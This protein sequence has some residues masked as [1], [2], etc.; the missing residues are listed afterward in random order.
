MPGIL[1]GE[2]PVSVH[3]RCA[4]DV[5]AAA[6]PEDGEIVPTRNPHLVP[7]L[8]TSSPQVRRPDAGRSPRDPTRPR[9]A[10][11]WE[12][13]VP[14]ASPRLPQLVHEVVPMMPFGVPSRSP[15]SPRPVLRLSAGCP[16][17]FPRG[18]PMFSPTCGLPGWAP[19]HRGGRRTAFRTCRLPRSSPS[20]AGP[21]LPAVT[22]SHPDR[23]GCGAARVGR[24]VRA[25]WVGGD[26]CGA[27][28]VRTAHYRP[29]AVARREVSVYVLGV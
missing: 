20:A 9:R 14:S 17:A 28:R 26:R 18:S 5:D 3:R 25:N 21:G 29:R 23:T 13:T 6:A 12:G 10:R 22:V 7:R 15:N 16:L 11:P 2:G 4:L 8:S 19:G 24:F 27:A 1:P